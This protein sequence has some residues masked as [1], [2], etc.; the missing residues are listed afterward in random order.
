[1]SV[2]NVVGAHASG[3]R[4]GAFKDKAV[5]EHLH[6]DFRAAYGVIA[7]AFAVHRELLQN[8]RR[9]LAGC[10]EPAVRT[11]ICP[12]RYLQFEQLCHLFDLTENCAFA[13]NVFYDVHFRSDFFFCSQI[14]DKAYSGTREES[15]R[16]FSEQ[17]YRG[18]A[19]AVA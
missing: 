7:M 4:A 2:A 14:F 18:G 1:M 3:Q 15:L 17:K 19:Y 16:I 9:I 11:E 5:V 10:N 6:L 8:E 12:F 13:G